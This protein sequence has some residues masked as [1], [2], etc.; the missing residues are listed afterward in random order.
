MSN[1]WTLYLAQFCSYSADFVRFHQIFLYM[2]PKCPNTLGIGSGHP[3][4]ISY[5]FK[6]VLEEGKKKSFFSPA[7][8]FFCCTSIREWVGCVWDPPK[9]IENPENLEKSRKIWRKKIEI[10][11]IHFWA[12]LSARSDLKLASFEP[13]ELSASFDYR[14]E[15]LRCLTKKIF[16]WHPSRKV[17]PIWDNCPNHTK[18]YCPY[19]MF[20]APK[21]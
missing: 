1:L 14:I 7:D 3:Q 10:R 13:P 16:S 2:P 11:K 8:F 12:L 21:I 5:H 4:Y 17:Q 18:E 6:H 19:H 15:K 20:F 9:N